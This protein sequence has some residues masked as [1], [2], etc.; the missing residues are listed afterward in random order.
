MRYERCLHDIATG[1]GTCGLYGLWDVVMR[2]T[3]E[4]QAQCPTSKWFTEY[5][6][7]TMAIFL[8]YNSYC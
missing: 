6:Y 4:G 8:E 3:S 2:G 7:A 1:F 5:Y